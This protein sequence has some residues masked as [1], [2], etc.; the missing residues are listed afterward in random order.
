MKATQRMYMELKYNST[1][2]TQKSI[3]LEHTP[4]EIN[5]KE[6]KMWRKRDGKIMVENQLW[7]MVENCKF[8]QR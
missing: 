3:Q 7:A 5:T 6:K 1:T 2:M 4:D 8:D